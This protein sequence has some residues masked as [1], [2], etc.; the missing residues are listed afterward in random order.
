M[1]KQFFKSILLSSLLTFP[2]SAFYLNLTI[3][4]AQ[5]RVGIAQQDNLT[6]TPTLALGENKVENI[7]QQITVK[8]NSG[9]KKGSGII[10]KKEGNLYTVLT[11][12]HVISSDKPINLTT[13]DG[14]VITATQIKGLNLDSLDVVLLQF[15]SA[16]NYT[17]AQFAN[18]DNLGE[19]TQI[20]AAG[21]PYETNKF[22]F[23]SGTLIKSPNQAFKN[24]YQLGY[25]LNY[26]QEIAK[27]MS[28][29][30]ILTEDG[31]VIGIN[32][33]HAG[34]VTIL[35]NPFVYQN[36]QK[37]T[38]AEMDRFTRYNWGI[39][40]NNIAKILPKYFSLQDTTITQQTALNTE[41]TVYN[42]V[43]QQAQRG[44]VRLE[45]LSENTRGS[46]V[47]V[48]KN[49]NTYYVLTGAH[50]VEELSAP[51][52]LE[53]ITP[54]GKTHKANNQSVIIFKGADMA[55]VEFTS[56][57]QYEQ[58]T[59]ATKKPNEGKDN[60]TFVA[61]F[62]ADTKE[63]T[64]TAG[65]IFDESRGSASETGNSANLSTGYDMVYTNI[66]AAGMSGGPV[67][68][69]RGNLVGIHGRVEGE[70]IINQ[71]TGKQEI[72]FLGH[73]FGVPVEIFLGRL[74]VCSIPPLETPPNPPLEGGGQ[75]YPPYEAGCFHSQ[76]L[77]ERKSKTFIFISSFLDF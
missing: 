53:I 1:F 11:N 59:I 68:D 69:L 9:D 15:N 66:T 24:G 56:E 21:F 74:Q 2:V 20:Y 37:P 64:F 50:V 19:N 4:L 8:I 77:N 23:V 46:G 6:I 57:Q 16:N 34:A 52:N 65:Q 61:G 14:K 71:A 32:G 18:A 17:I 43:K 36:G 62:P 48:G 26:E 70:N 31:K 45:L 27:G 41:K 12:R 75:L 47:I 28:G 25:D 67:L 29:G 35:Y 73:S 3:N 39:P 60:F 51:R 22:T 54:D 30:P 44:T 49:N 42:E 10:I 76:N 38:A 72:V 40:V 63:F 13:P 33:I 55:L 7:A 5:S 58:V